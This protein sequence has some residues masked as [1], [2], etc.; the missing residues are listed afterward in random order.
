MAIPEVSI[1]SRVIA[2]VCAPIWICVSVV[3]L[4]TGFGAQALAIGVIVVATISIFGNAAVLLWP[5]P[6]PTPKPLFE[7]DEVPFAV[8]PWTPE[9]KKPWR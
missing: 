3:V 5:K 2:L 6:T 8:S 1:T 4:V 9:E 7:P